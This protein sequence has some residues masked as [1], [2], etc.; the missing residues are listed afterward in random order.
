MRYCLHTVVCSPPT[1]GCNQ[2]PTYPDLTSIHQGEGGRVCQSM[3]RELMR[4]MF[5]GLCADTCSAPSSSRFVVLTLLQQINMQNLVNG[6]QCVVMRY[7]VRV[8]MTEDD[9][10]RVGI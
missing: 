9:R 5:D 6:G 3:A 2:C 4:G 8:P 10:L 1:P 7:W